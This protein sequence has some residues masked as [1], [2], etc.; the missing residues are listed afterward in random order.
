MYISNYQMQ[1]VLNVYSKHLSQN[2]IAK[3]ENLVFNRPPADQ[4][5]LSIKSKR[6]QAMEKVA[7][8]IFNKIGHLVSQ[9]GASQKS[10]KLSPSE[11]QRPLGS[12]KPGETE[13]VFNVIDDIDHKTT[14]SLSLEDS[15]FLI[16]PFD[17]L[18]QEAV[19]KEEEPQ[20]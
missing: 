11:T 3:K 6:Q 5:T 15:S 12:E 16:K 9:E 4:F 8:D 14:T 17:Q 19:E 13:F 18:T 20:D 10:A 1:N 2:R 7:K